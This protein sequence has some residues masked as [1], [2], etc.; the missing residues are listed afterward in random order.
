V[1]AGVAALGGVVAIIAAFLTWVSASDGA[2]SISVKGT[3]G[4]RDGNITLVLG[5]AVAIVAGLLAWRTI[6]GLSIG[7][8]V[9][10]ALIAIVAIIDISD[11]D[12]DSDLKSL[13]VDVSIG[14]GLWLTLAAGIAVL[15]AGLW[16]LVA[17]KRLRAF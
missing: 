9:L 5:I 15:A 10:G 2:L 4:G 3:D 12:G 6:L 17:G 13:G 7:T 11:P 14:V 16:A 8:M 1:P